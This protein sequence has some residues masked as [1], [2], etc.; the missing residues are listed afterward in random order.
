MSKVS[1]VTWW[2]RQTSSKVERSSSVA[3]SVITFFWYFVTKVRWV[4]FVDHLAAVEGLVFCYN[5]SSICRPHR[6]GWLACVTVTVLSPLLGGSKC[7]CGTARMPVTC[8][9]WRWSKRTCTGQVWAAPRTTTGR[10]PNWRK[11]ARPPGWGRVPP[12]CS[13]RRS[14]TSI[15][16]CGTGGAVP[17]AVR[18]GVA[19]SFTSPSVSAT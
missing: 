19:G 12:R 1:R 10:P 16:G 9:T 18:R 11:P 7:W 17:I 5:T 15:R 2:R 4:G 14:R 8:G 6:L 3:R 13:R